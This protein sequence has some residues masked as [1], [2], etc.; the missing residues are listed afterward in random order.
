V[1][2][3]DHAELISFKGFGKTFVIKAGDL[4]AATDINLAIP[5]A[6]RSSTCGSNLSS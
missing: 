1:T 6:R 5:Q 4:R 2:V 3:D